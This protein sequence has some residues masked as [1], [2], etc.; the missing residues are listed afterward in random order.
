M[1]SAE[2][3]WEIRGKAYGEIKQPAAAAPSL[4][5]HSYNNDTGVW[6]RH[7]CS[8]SAHL[9]GDN[10]HNMWVKTQWKQQEAVSTWCEAWCE[11]YGAYFSFFLRTAAPLLLFLHWSSC[12]TNL[13]NTGWLHSSTYTALHGEYSSDN[14]LI[15]YNCGA[16]PGL[17]WLMVFE[18][19]L[20]WELYCAEML[21]P[22]QGDHTDST[23]TWLWKQTERRPGSMH[24]LIWP[25][26]F[27]FS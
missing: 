3:I 14:C 13:L 16:V 2:I 22:L 23:R 24:S 11:T 17:V 12:I 7:T 6:E 10:T 26:G 21:Q 8:D 9:S 4:M 5:K 1:C 27:H 18:M 25:C 15:C 19:H 20:V